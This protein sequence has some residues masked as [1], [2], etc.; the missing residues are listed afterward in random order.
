MTYLGFIYC[1]K[2]FSLKM[3]NM[4]RLFY[5]ILTNVKV[6][7]IALRESGIQVNKRE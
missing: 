5:I 3:L 1:G 6:I 2:Y 7:E 4:I